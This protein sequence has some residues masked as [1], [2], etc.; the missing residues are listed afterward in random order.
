MTGRKQVIPVVKALNIPMEDQ[1][2]DDLETVRAFFSEEQGVRFNKSMAMKKL[3]HECA[4]R[5]R[6]TGRIWSDDQERSG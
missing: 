5:I 6:D 2:H 4:I 1:Y 3:L